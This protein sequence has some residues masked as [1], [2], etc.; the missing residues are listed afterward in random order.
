MGN[1]EVAEHPQPEPVGGE[2]QVLVWFETHV[3]PH[4]P[5]VGARLQTGQADIDF[6]QLRLLRLVRLSP[7]RLPL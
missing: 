4:F 1:A 6:E 7:R 3:Q 5:L 2:R